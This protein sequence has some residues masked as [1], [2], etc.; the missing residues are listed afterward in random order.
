MFS[1]LKYLSGI[2]LCLSILG[3][4]SSEERQFVPK[5]K[6]YNRIDLPKQDYQK[7]AEKHPYSFEHSIHSKI[8]PDTSGIAE[9][10]WIHVF[11]PKFRADVQLTY[12]SVAA[13]PSFFDDFIDDSHRLISKHFIKAYAVEDNI[14][15]T[16]SGKTAVVYELEG[17]VPSQF[18]F[19]ISDSTNHFL[20]GAL[21]FRTATK[22][23]SL[24][25]VIEFI[26]KDIIHMLN[27]MDW[28]DE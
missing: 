19:Y 18:Q 24:A 12:K 14:L 4:C 23:D 2:I 15:K 5:P 27:T 1:I 13:N 25:P 22:N 9:P 11:Y 6:G 28:V 21:Y 8:L 26:K 10:H 16:P 3:A 7:L 20:R 17:E